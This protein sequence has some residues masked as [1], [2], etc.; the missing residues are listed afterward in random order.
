MS[1]TGRL[2][3]DEKDFCSNFDP[4]AIGIVDAVAQVL[5]PEYG[6]VS[7]ETRGL[8]AELYKLNVSLSGSRWLR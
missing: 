7:N 4:C 6:G 1:R 2:E 8:R 5:M 3:R